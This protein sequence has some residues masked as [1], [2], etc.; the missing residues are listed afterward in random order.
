M[1]VDA[2][3]TY[4]DATSGL[5]E[6]SRKEAVA[7]AKALLKASGRPAAPAAPAADQEAMPARVGQSIQALAG[8]L[9]ATNEANRTAIADLVRSEVAHQ[10]E[11]MDIVPRTEY[12]RVVRR[13]AELERRLA[14]RHMADRVPLN[15]VP[16][17]AAT[18]G[19]VLGGASVA[20]ARTGGRADAAE[21]EASA[22]ESEDPAPGAAAVAGGSGASTDP[23]TDTAT[24]SATEDA[25]EDA[26]PAAGNGAEKESGSEPEA[27][28]TGAKGV[29]AKGAEGAATARKTTS[30]SKPRTTTKSARARSAPKRTTE[31]KGSTGKGPT[32]K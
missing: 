5:T 28:A 12:E 7:A 14:A 10:L 23:A 13:V 26:A 22:D 30:R 4:S 11:R 31:A 2:V 6:L 16:V 29:G 32:K 24:D 20:D 1:V 19:T 18:A 21:P 8:E 17:V 15:E 3:R 27:A 25:D 9:I